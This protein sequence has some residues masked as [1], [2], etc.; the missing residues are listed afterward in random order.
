[1]SALTKHYEFTQAELYV[2]RDALIEYKHFLASLTGDSE[3]RTKT[4]DVTYALVE[5]F[6][7]DVRLT[8]F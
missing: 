2:I 7:D 8:N 4:R 1:M 3:T 6:K 5:Q